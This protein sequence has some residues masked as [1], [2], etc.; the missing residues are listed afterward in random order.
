[1]TPQCLNNIFLLYIH[2]KETD[3]LDFIAIAKDFVSANT[4]RKFFNLAISIN[5]ILL[6]VIM[7]KK[8]NLSNLV[9][10]TIP[11]KTV[12]WGEVRHAR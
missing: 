3:S 5:C 8:K 1:M 12:F 6:M 11:K 10:N 2:K 9:Q 7:I 4:R